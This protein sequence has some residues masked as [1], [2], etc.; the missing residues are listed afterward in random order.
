MGDSEEYSNL[1][2]VKISPDTLEKYKNDAK[3]EMRQRQQEYKS[4]FNSPLASMNE[5]VKKDLHHFYGLTK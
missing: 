5:K 2:D 1:V 4:T 3:N